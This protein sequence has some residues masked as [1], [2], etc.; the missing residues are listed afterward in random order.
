MLL[1]STRWSTQTGRAVRGSV[2]PSDLR[3]SAAQASPIGKFHPANERL[4][5]FD[6]RNLGSVHI[7]EDRDNVCYTMRSYIVAR[8]NRNSDSTKLVG[9]ST[10]QTS[11]KY[12]LRITVEDPKECLAL[13][14][15]C[16]V[17]LQASPPLAPAVPPRAHNPAGS[18]PGGRLRVAVG[19]N[20]YF[21]IVHRS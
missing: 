16:S 2:A 19:V 12:E 11:S 20:A 18:C 6:L 4:H 3:N 1:W 5:K 15:G 7:E 9:Y 14:A 8:E 17:A 10:C 21:S 13:L